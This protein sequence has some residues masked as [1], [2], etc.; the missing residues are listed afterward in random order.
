MEMLLICPVGEK[1]RWNERHYQCQW[2]RH[3]SDS[4]SKAPPGRSLTCSVSLAAMPRSCP[5]PYCREKGSPPCSYESDRKDLNLWCT[6]AQNRSH[7]HPK[8]RARPFACSPYRTGCDPGKAALTFG[9]K[10]LSVEALFPCRHPIFS[11]L[12]IPQGL[13]LV[14]NSP[15]PFSCLLLDAAHPVCHQHREEQASKS[16]GLLQALPPTNPWQFQR[17]TPWPLPNFAH[18][19]RY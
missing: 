2:I 6:P 1:K 14:C 16:L 10:K 11:A 4:I 9:V 13:F 7:L 12:G 5:V 8:G 18:T 3:I 19:W 15:G 17:A